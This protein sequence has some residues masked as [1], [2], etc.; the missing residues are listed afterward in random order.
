KYSPF[1]PEHKDLYFNYFLDEIKLL[2]KIYHKNIVRVF[3]YYLYPEQMTGYILMEF[4]KG[5]NIDEYISENPD[6]L[7]DLFVQIIN[8]FTYL[9]ENKI[10]HRD[11][12]PDNILVTVDGVT[13]II[14]FG[15]GKLID[16]DN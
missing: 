4:V 6:R 5:Q 2:H 16:F 12:R 3:N 15:F 9:E 13:K 14:D 11:I 8:G 1:Y 7:S 10:L